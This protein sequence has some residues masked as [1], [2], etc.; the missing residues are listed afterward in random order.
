MRPVVFLDTETTH[1]DRRRRAWEI[2]MIRRDTAG[3]RELTL[4]VDVDVDVA[5]LDLESGEM[6]R[7]AF[8]E[9]TQDD[10][11][12]GQAVEHPG[13]HQTQCVQGSFV[14][15][16]VARSGKHASNRRL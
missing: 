14:V 15:P 13:S 9:M 2:A 6:E 3:E 7:D 16:A 4:F 1:R 11:Q 8:A 12:C 10:L 5:D